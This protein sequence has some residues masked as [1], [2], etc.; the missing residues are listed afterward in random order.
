[1]L[2]QLEVWMKTLKVVISNIRRLAIVH[3]SV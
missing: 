2:R 1:M 3:V